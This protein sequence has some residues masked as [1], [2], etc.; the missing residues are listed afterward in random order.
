MPL[1]GSLEEHVL[2]S[3]VTINLPSSPR[4]LTIH[5]C[6]SLC[7]QIYIE[8]PFAGRHDTK[9]QGNLVNAA[10]AT[11]QKLEGRFTKN[12]PDTRCFGVKLAKTAKVPGLNLLAIRPAVWLARSWQSPFNISS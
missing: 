8:I 2:I 1:V 11:W 4:M 10:G 3:H 12:L 9:V 5:H 6:G 7:G